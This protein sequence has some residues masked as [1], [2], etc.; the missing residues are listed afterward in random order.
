[1]APWDAMYLTVNSMTGIGW[2][3]S[4]PPDHKISNLISSIDDGIIRLP[5]SLFECGGCFSAASRHV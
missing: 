4:S 1:M 5:D 3:V 2:Y